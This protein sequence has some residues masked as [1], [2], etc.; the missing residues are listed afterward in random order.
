MQLSSRDEIWSSHSCMARPACDAV[1]LGVYSRI[2][3]G[4]NAFITILGFFETS[5]ITST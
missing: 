1:P 3:L 4:F 2:F 5:G